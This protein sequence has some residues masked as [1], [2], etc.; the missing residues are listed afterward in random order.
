[1][2]FAVVWLRLPLEMNCKRG[3]GENFGESGK[4]ILKTT[5]WL[6][7]PDW[8]IRFPW[9]IHDRDNHVFRCRTCVHA[10]AR[11]VFVSGKDA[12]KPKKDDLVFR[13]QKIGTATQATACL[14]HCQGHGKWT[15]QVSH[16]RSVEDSPNTSKALPP[17]GQE[18][19]P[20]GATSF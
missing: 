12:N 18:C 13:P 15:R 19:G 4:K 9:L 8:F 5:T 3:T 14:R 6:I 17:N 2:F 11:N 20:S 16:Y 1:M 10:K 7:K